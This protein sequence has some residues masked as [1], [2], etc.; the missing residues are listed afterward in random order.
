MHRRL[1]FAWCRPMCGILLG[2][3][4]WLSS[5]AYCSSQQCAAAQAGGAWLVGDAGSCRVRSSER[6]FAANY[7][8]ALKRSDVERWPIARR[9][10]GAV[11]QAAPLGSDGVCP[12]SDQSASECVG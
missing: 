5:S 12:G 4:R 10:H 1:R 7:T 8:L 6:G 2:A 11:R 3:E 9:L